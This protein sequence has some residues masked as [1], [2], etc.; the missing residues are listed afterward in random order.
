VGVAYRLMYRL[1]FT[2]WDRM[3]PAELAAAMEGPGARPPGRALDMGS[4]LGTKAVFMATHGWRVTAV[5][6][7]PRALEEARR[8]A[9][10]AGVKIDFRRGDVTRLED[11]KLEPG[12]NLV[13]DFG[14][15]HGLN[16]KQRDAY[17]RG[18]NALV[19]PGA[20]LLMMAFTKPVPPVTSGVSESEL[21]ERFG[22]EWRSA[23]SHA[24]QIDNE[25]T[26]S[27]RGAAGWFQ[28]VRT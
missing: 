25:S 4:G 24:A 3:L 9:A 1:G 13:F 5:E 21:L 18:V 15:F 19:A 16:G 17:A 8:R 23:G 22:P 11:L 14:C 26:A 2:P 20:T 27:R 12:F 7:V 28:L 10:K 6:S